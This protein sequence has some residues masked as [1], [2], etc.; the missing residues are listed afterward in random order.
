MTFASVLPALVALVLPQTI[1][2]P[3]PFPETH[4]VASESSF[5]APGVTYASYDIR[6]SEGPLN[7]HVIAVDPKEPTLRID[8]VLASDRII[9]HGETVSSMAHRT[10]A[11]AGINGDYFD[12]GNT[13]QPLNILISG[14][15]LLRM[16]MQRYALAI[17]N[18]RRAQFSEFQ[19]GA[20]I[21]IG[22]ASLPV[23]A[24]NDWPQAG[25]TLLTP[26]FGTVAPS[27]NA[28]VVRLQPLG[29]KPPFGAYRV[30][31][32]VDNTNSQPPGYYLGIGSNAYA[33]TAVPDVGDTVLVRSAF[34]PP[35]DS[36]Q[37]AIGGGP[38]LLRDGAYYADPDGPNTG[39]FLTHMPV[40]GAAMRADGTL[41]FFEVDG[42]QPELSIGVTQPEFSALMRAFG[43]TTGMAFD[44]GGSATLVTRRLG[45][46]D[47][48]VRNSPSD[49]Q[50]RRVGD[51]LFF[52]SD[53]PQGPP[54]RLTAEPSVLRALPGAKIAFRV[55]TTD[56]AGHP[57]DSGAPVRAALDP[58]S[59][60]KLE[61]TQFSAERV[62]SGMLALRRGALHADVPV[63]VTDTPARVEI[64]PNDA[65]VSKGESLHLRARAFD[66]RGYAIAL[67]DMLPWKSEGGAITRDGTFTAGDRDATVSLQAGA[68]IAS[69]HITVGQHEQELQLGATSFATIP[70]NG[71]GDLTKGAD[72]P[73][74]LSLAY[75][76]SGN[77]RAAYVQ[78]NVQLPKAVGIVF[79]VLGDNNR[80]FVRVAVDNAINERVA[81]TA[82]RVDWTGWRT[83]SVKFPP[84]L[85]Q[86]AR[87]RSIYVLKEFS[88]ESTDT[89]GHIAIRNVRLILAGSAQQRPQ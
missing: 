65:N 81:F 77:E 1:D 66:A 79:D 88:G 29:D 47:A 80:E 83:V 48:T 46:I 43:A 52:Y 6:T 9:S 64:F 76:F 42:R 50:E 49:G 71:P 28:T 3:H 68:A 8:T 16:P 36:L 38:L 69:T 51:G 57:A 15:R 70:R 32:V 21:E 74:C 84:T 55:A 13:N 18:D 59:L 54:A 25:I 72:C 40:S 62:G 24:L 82:A 60:G 73:V 17:D 5:V 39:E 34:T 31:D 2:P 19:F 89:S 37:T 44:A 53:A 12:I 7:L 23:N 58:S 75:D 22:A 30:L 78:T 4:S 20:T 45:D 67:P 33:Q 35:I 41:L 11:V 10:G 85:P 26:E 86:P 14:G 27:S 87:L 61:G 56:A 63:T